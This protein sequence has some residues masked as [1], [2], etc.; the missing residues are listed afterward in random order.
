MYMDVYNFEDD[1]H[2]LFLLAI[3]LIRSHPK[4]SFSQERNHFKKVICLHFEEKHEIDQDLHYLLP[5][6]Q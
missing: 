3:L 4:L 2:Q 6:L 1:N 5:N